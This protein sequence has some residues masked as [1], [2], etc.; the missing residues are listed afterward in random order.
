MGDDPL[1]QIVGL[2]PVGDRQL[3]QFRHETPVP[4]EHP[5][6]QAVMAEVVEAAVLAVPLPGCVNQG[7]I[8]R[9]AL[10]MHIGRF[11]FEE[12]ILK[13]HGDIL[14]EADP[15]ETA[16]RHGIAIPYQAHRIAGGDY[17]SRIGSAQ[18]RGHGVT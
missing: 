16:G 5:A 11:P 18:R 9:A 7:Q 15:D 10:A 14:G 6:N 3:L 1:R 12:K 8:A 17:L 2:D 13:R 4:A